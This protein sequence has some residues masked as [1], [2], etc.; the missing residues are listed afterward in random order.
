MKEMIW[1]KEELKN[2]KKV[3]LTRA[4]L[5]FNAEGELVNI[6]KNEIGDIRNSSIIYE[7][8]AKELEALLFIDTREEIINVLNKTKTIKA[9]PTNP[10]HYGFVMSLANIN[11]N[12]HE[13][14]FIIFKEIIALYEKTIARIAHLAVDNIVDLHELRELSHN[15][16]NSTEITVEEML[17]INEL[18][19]TIALVNGTIDSPL[20]TEL[21]NNL[22]SSIKNSLIQK[23]NVLVSKKIK[24]L[25]KDKE[26]EKDNYLYESVL[27]Q[28]K[29][30]YRQK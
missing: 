15:I 30:L 10:K 29:K 6:S 26:A 5:K 3:I 16:H 23:I 9:D 27:K 13:E 19:K 25:Y 24:S 28:R 4:N 2:I 8:H 12:N 1:T 17:I 20:F 21:K 18:N 14:I 22:N 11:P 7:H